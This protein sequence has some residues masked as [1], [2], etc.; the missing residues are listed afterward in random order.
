MSEEK[1]NPEV[2][3]PEVKQPENKKVASLKPGQVRFQSGNVYT[4]AVVKGAS[5]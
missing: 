3:A 1:K 2:K 4:P 5:K